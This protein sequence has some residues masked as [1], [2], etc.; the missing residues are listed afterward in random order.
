MPKVTC[1]GGHTSPGLR[2]RE[3]LWNWKRAPWK[4]H[5]PTRSDGK[6]PDVA[7]LLLLSVVV[8]MIGLPIMM[9][10]DPN[11]KR[12]L[13][14]TILLVIAFNLLYLFAVRFIYPHLQ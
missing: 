3:R 10:R 1:A 12:G 9:A 5:Q 14:R 13:N 11:A 6:I 4:S 2:T 7:K 8:V